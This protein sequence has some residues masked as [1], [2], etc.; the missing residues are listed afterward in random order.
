[1]IFLRDGI[2]HPFIFLSKENKCEICDASTWLG[3]PLKLELHHVDGNR[4]NN[5]IDNIQLLC[6]NCHSYTGNYKGKN[7]RKMVDI[8]PDM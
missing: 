2:Y 5:L 7:I 6:P 8:K 4:N 3:K 1:M